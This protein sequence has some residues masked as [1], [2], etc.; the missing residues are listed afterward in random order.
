MAYSSDSYRKVKDELRES[1]ERAEAEATARRSE[2]HEAHPDIAT[3]DAALAE[4]GMRLFKIALSGGEDARRRLA[5]LREENAAMLDLRRKLLVA[6]GYPEDAT[7]PRYACGECHDSG[8]IGTKMCACMRRR[9]ILEGFRESGIGGLIDRQS[10]DNFSLDYY[11]DERE[12]DEMRFVFERA[13]KF[14][15]TFGTD[16]APCK[17]LMFIGGTG[18]GKTHLS[19]AI[20]RRVIER[21]YDVKYESA[22]N[23]ISDFEDERFGGERYYSRGNSPTDKYFE[24]DLLIIDDLGAEMVNQF[25]LSSLYNLINTRQNRGLGMLISTNLD[26]KELRALYNDRITSRLFGEFDILRFRGSDNRGL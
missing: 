20:A 9:L 19:T 4:T 7:E 10:F 2:I 25:T 24:C 6:A 26:G 11:R 12:R 17:N 5:K 1:R 15:E 18:L 16:A 21:G 13:K 8:Y 22:P 23:I 3:V 14:A